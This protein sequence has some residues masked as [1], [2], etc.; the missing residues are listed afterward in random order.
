M[1]SAALLQGASLA[2][3][4]LPETVP[5]V[6]LAELAEALP[7]LRPA[8]DWPETVYGEDLAVGAALQTAETLAGQVGGLTPQ[9]GAP[10]LLQLRG[11]LRLVQM[12]LGAL[13]RRQDAE[14]TRAGK[15][16]AGRG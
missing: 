11:L 15:R 8:S 6:S 3:L 14:A 7:P 5:G 9:A 16:L 1:R 13:C 10:A 2:L 4:T 12:Q